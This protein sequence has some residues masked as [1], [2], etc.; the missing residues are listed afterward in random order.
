MVQWGARHLHLPCPGE[1]N[2]LHP[3]LGCPTSPI[4]RVGVRSGGVRA[5]PVDPQLPAFAPACVMSWISSPPGLKQQNVPRDTA[6]T[7]S[8]G[9]HRDA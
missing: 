7:L 3:P 6:G 9:S 8:G 1:Q 5:S 2:I 4:G